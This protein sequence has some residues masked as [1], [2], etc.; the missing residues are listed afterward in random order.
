MIKNN[1]LLNYEITL[2]IDDV[3]FLEKPK[4]QNIIKGIRKRLAKGT[5]TIKV[6]K[7][8]EHIERGGSFT[9]AAIFATSAALTPDT[10]SASSSGLQIMPRITCER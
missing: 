2:N 1:A 4:E 5:R 7:L 10:S 8:M 9:P 6:S 3:C